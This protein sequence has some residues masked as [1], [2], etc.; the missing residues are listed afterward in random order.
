MRVLWK[1]ARKLKEPIPRPIVLAIMQGVLRGLAAAH[2]ARAEDGQPLGIVHRDVSPQ[3]VLVG[4][5]GIP[6]IIDFGVAKAFGKLE[7]TRPGEIQGKYRYMAPEHLMGRPVTVQA[8]VYAA[9]VIMWELLAGRRLFDADD[10]SAVCAAVIQGN[11]PKPSTVSADVPPELDEIV[12]RATARELSSR[13]FDA[14][15]MLAALQPFERA[16]EE[17]VGAWVRSLVADTIEEHRK[18]IEAA[19]GPA[20]TRSLEALLSEL[21]PS[22]TGS[23]PSLPSTSGTTGPV[24]VPGPISNLDVGEATTRE[25][26]R[27]PGRARAPEMPWLIAMAAFGTVALVGLVLGVLS[28]SKASTKEAEVPATTA[29]SAAV[30]IASSAAP[31]ETASAAPSA[32]APPTPA[33]SVTATATIATSPPPPPTR[34]RKKP[35]ANA[36]PAQP[37][38]PTDRR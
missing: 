10:E 14:R 34:V 1:R 33:A 16:A 31:A 32:S 37:Q 25:A 17:E 18:M 13:Y 27:A 23:S 5:D 12:L 15:E 9:G 35:R 38:D 22:R 3:N 29:T 26:P 28:I 36:Q 30:P 2:E 11:I 24:S 21:A 20:S 4:V 19:S 7:A 8:D 6:R